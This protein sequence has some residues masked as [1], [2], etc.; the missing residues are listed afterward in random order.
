MENT[1]YII[2]NP[3]SGNGLVQRKWK[4]VI[5][6]LDQNNLLYQ[7]TFSEYEHH[8][9]ELVHKALEKGFKTLAGEDFLRGFPDPF[10]PRSELISL[11]I[12]HPEKT[13]TDIMKREKRP[14]QLI[15]PPTS[16]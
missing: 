10:L 3:T 8:E 2:A 5:T 14:T 9:Q 6:S 15:I 1:W 11:E 12:S 4:R 13:T 16:P 7:F